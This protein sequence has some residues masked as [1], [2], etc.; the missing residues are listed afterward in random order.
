M[1]IFSAGELFIFTS[2]T[3]FHKLRPDLAYLYAL[4]H[5]YGFY[6]AFIIIL[7]FS[8]L[9]PK[10]LIAFYAFC[11][12]NKLLGICIN[13]VEWILCLDTKEFVVCMSYWLNDWLMIEG[14]F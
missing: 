7:L 2:E 9:F 5:F 1:N 11:L 10:F 6:L 8:I 3:D 13:W 4:E 14:K 12:M